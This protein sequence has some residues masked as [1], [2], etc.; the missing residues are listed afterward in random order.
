M[1]IRHYKHVLLFILLEYQQ[2]WGSLT[3]SFALED[4]EI[5]SLCPSG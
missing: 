4:N 1:F 5:C 3:K 2:F